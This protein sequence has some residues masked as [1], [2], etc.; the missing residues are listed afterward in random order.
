[1]L[2]KMPKLSI[3]ISAVILLS[4]SVQTSSGATS[5]SSPF[6]P[7]LVQPKTSTCIIAGTPTIY[8][9]S[10]STLATT[11]FTGSVTSVYLE[12][13][14]PT[15]YQTTR[16]ANSGS[17]QPT[18]YTTSPNTGSF[19]PTTYTTSPNG[20]SF[21]PTTYTTS[22]SFSPTTYTTSPNGGSFSP[23]TYTTSP[24]GGSFS[25]TTYTTSPN[26]GSFSPTTYSTLQSPNSGSYS[27]NRYITR[28]VITAGSAAQ[29]SGCAV[30]LSVTPR[31]PARVGQ[32]GLTI[33]AVTNDSDGLRFSS[34]SPGVCSINAISGRLTLLSK[35]ICRIEVFVSATSGFV[36]AR[37]ATTTFSV[38]SPTAR[39]LVSCLY[40]NSAYRVTALCR[41]L[42]QN[43]V[44]TLRP[45][46]S[47]HFVVNGYTTVAG[48]YSYNLRLSRLRTSEVVAAVKQLFRARGIT[49]YTLTVNSYGST[50]LKQR[51]V[52]IVQG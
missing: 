16:A 11:L 43:F 25:P 10:T 33:T 2:T 46:S 29:N 9:Y 26:N 52:Q 5:N 14:S 51:L 17:Y 38:T 31:G 30:N 19:S 41:H 6:S 36:G 34:L 7:S 40:Q 3:A 47:G 21:S 13:G 20:G 22:T 4:L 8:S 49:H 37:S 28:T 35:G 15:T 45:S 27:A 23:T 1:M 24:N 39:V 44:A 42:I 50:K 18:T 12:T 32:V 48:G